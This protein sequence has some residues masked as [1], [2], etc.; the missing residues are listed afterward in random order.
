MAVITDNASNNG[1]ITAVLR[2]E[3]KL[4]QRSY[5][6]IVDTNIE[7]GYKTEYL[8]YLAYII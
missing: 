5:T 1:S 4:R 8:L 7:P 3:S 6:N 2:K